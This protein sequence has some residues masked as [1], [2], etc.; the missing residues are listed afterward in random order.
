MGPYAGV[1]YNLFLCPLHRLL[2]HI[3]RGQPCARVDLI[4]KSGSFGFG[5]CSCPLGVSF[6][7]GV[8]IA[9]GGDSVCQRVNGILC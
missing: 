6:L 5:L 8:L 2:Q 4:P 9:G 7:E 1:D 3:Y